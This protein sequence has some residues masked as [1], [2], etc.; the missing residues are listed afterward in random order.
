MSM[1]R[2]FFSAIL[3]GISISSVAAAPSELSKIQNQI[4]QTE[5]K[6]KQIEQQLKTST[7]D[8]EKTKKQ[9]VKTADKVSDLEEQRGVLIKRIA[10]LDKQR[11]K[12]NA[13]LSQNY[14]DI[15]NATAGMLFIAAGHAHAPVRGDG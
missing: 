9:L 3:F 2:A 14:N 12:I 4:K 8:V 11:D 6:N 15:A 10:E 5:Q 1:N 13:D 7:K